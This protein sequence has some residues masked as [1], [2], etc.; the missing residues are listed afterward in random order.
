MLTLRPLALVILLLAGLL[1]SCERTPDAFDT[2]A[3]TYSQPELTI[4]VA[5]NFHFPLSELIKNS[6]Y[7]SAQPIRLV[8]GSSGTLYAQFIN[9]A[10]FDLFFSADAQ[11]PLRLE[12]AGLTSGRMTYA[13]GK[14][15]L[16]TGG[17]NPEWL[18]SNNAMNISGKLAIANPDLAPFGAA[19]MAYIRSLSNSKALQHQLVLGANVTQAFQFVDSGNA[20]A[21]LLA[22][23]VLINA[24][25]NLKKPQYTHYV[26]IPS[27]LYP[28]IVQ[29]VVIANSSS[30]KVH[31]QRF[32]DFISTSK[33]QQQLASLGY[34]PFSGAKQ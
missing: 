23:S 2:S 25:N 11:R 15:V 28:T 14:L 19:A 7:W 4:A 12:H 21:A 6:D 8:V 5:S 13:I 26:I 24:Q 1:L 17:V 27:E 20:Q 29:Q 30:S 18:L 22:E 31:A 9:G 10:P 33:A 34:T 3:S 32:I 16:Y